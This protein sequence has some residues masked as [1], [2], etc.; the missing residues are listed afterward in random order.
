MAST[1]AGNG[2]YGYSGDGGTATSAQVVP[3]QIAADASGTVFIVDTLD[4]RLR[5]VSNGIITTVAGTGKK[6]YSSDGVP[7]ASS[8][9][10]EPA[11][12]AVGG[13]GEL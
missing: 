11:A 7:A 10:G 4:Y 5:K 6:Q 13:S 8:P 12:L 9:I 2:S 3:G 1:Y